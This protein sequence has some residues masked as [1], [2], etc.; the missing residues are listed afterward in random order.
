MSR[1][2]RHTWLTFAWLP[3]SHIVLHTGHVCCIIHTVELRIFEQTTFSVYLLGSLLLWFPGFRSSRYWRVRYRLNLAEPAQAM[4][5]S[6]GHKSMQ[7]GD[8]YLFQITPDGPDWLYLILV[9]WETLNSIPE[10]SSGLTGDW[11]PYL[12]S[13]KPVLYHWATVLLINISGLNTSWFIKNMHCDTMYMI[14]GAFRTNIVVK[15]AF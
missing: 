14:A 5:T 8:S 3:T 4:I 1:F 10:I 12:S 13:V 2:W 15:C 9:E 11:T 6:R 7:D